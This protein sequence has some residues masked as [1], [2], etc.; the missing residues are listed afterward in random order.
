MLEYAKP[1]KVED[2][3]DCKN[4]TPDYRRENDTER[5]VEIDGQEL[6]LMLYDQD[7]N[8]LATMSCEMDR[9]DRDKKNWQQQQVKLGHL[10]E[11][12]RDAITDLIV[13]QNVAT[14]SL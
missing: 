8:T 3:T 4:F 14:L 11:E 13:R 7:E 9:V 5:D 1:Q 10:S 12:H 6:V 2:G